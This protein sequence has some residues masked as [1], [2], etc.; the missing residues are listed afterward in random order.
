M[1]G[2]TV[3]SS[4]CRFLYVMPGM[5][6]GVIF[7]IVLSEEPDEDMESKLRIAGRFTDKNRPCPAATSLVRYFTI[8]PS[9]APAI[10]TTMC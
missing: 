6:L 8:V 1:T 7:V 9:A 2:G 5:N 4:I 10:V 3:V